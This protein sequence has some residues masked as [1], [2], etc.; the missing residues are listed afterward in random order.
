VRAHAAAPAARPERTEAGRIE[1]EPTE[2]FDK[3][4]K[5]SP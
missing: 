5:K 4:L 1:I 3:I 2:I